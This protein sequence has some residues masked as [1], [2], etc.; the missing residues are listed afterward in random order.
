MKYADARPQ[1]KTGDL[2]AWSN[3]GWGSWHDIQVN[4]VR[5]FTRSEYSHVGLAWVANGRVFI[6]E[7]VGTGVRIFPLSREIPFYWVRKPSPLTQEAIEFLFERIGAPY[8]KW[9]A[10]LAGIGALAKGR[11]DIWQ[12]AELV[13]SALKL[14]DDGLGDIDAT[15]TAVVKEAMRQWGAVQFIEEQV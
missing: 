4:F 9:Q 7:A 5:M 11:D 1:I 13:L 8:S 2:L 3:G 10:I 6:I 12:C 14:D 15:P